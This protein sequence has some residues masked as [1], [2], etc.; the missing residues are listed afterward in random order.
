MRLKLYR[1]YKVAC[2]WLL[3]PFFNL[4]DT[5]MSVVFKFCKTLAPSSLFASASLTKRQEENSKGTEHTKT[6]PA[7]NK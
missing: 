2:D 4:K 5:G 6:Q 7:L 1:C 3:K